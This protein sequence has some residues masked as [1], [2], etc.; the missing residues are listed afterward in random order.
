ML[1]RISNQV[2]N[3][4]I[5]TKVFGVILKMKYSGEVHSITPTEM[6]KWPPWP[7]YLKFY[8]LL[9]Y[10]YP[11]IPT[12]HTHSQLASCSEP[13]FLKWISDEDMMHVT[14]SHAM[15][16]LEQ[17]YSDIVLGA[18]TIMQFQEMEKK[19]EQLFQLCKAASS[20]T[21]QQYLAVATLQL[22]MEKHKSEYVRLTNKVGQ[23]KTLFSK[24]SPYLR[25]ESKFLF[26]IS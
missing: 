22:Q 10:Q 12:K 17:V 26:A 11:T 8:S 25:I 21:D 18:I 5:V 23:F 14:C 6:F 19:K 1:E 7:I 24:V 2:S 3:K 20:S 9:G 15:A 4:K 16:V 13:S